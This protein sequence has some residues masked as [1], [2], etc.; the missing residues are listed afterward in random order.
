MAKT[1]VTNH[2]FYVVDLVRKKPKTQ[3]IEIP[4]YRVDVNIEVTT[5]ALLKTPKPAPSTAL[6]RLETAARDE[7]G[8]YETVIA[9]EAK[10]L[11]AKVVE[12]MKQ[13]SKAGEAEANKMIETTNSMI[14]KALAS[15][16]GA[17]QKAVEKR[18]KKE[19]QGDKLL[20]EA[21]VKTTVKVGKAIIKVS[22]SVAKLVAT[23]GAD[24]TS[25]KTIVTETVKMGL[26]LKQ[27]LKNEAKLRKDLDKAVLT[28]IK[29]RGS[30]IRQAIERQG[31][32]DTSGIDFTKPLVAIKGA[33]KKIQA[34][35]AEV[36]KGKDPKAILKNI[37]DF[38]IKSIKSYL[39]DCEKA[40]KAY[41]EHTTKTR[42][43]TDALGGSADKLM[44]AAKSAKSLK[45]GVR[46]G[47]ECMSI[48]R[49]ATAMGVKLDTREKYLDDMQ[50]LMKMNGL[51]IDDKTT[52]QKLKALDASTILTEGKGL[53]DTVKEVKGLVDNVVDAVT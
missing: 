37:A 21:R 43:K 25:Y 11:D 9:A 14:L 34:A 33:V 12:L 28:F 52:I 7:L 20:K 38:T 27:Q 4:A 29:L 41:R 24:V 10:R 15:A 45:E 6:K 53:I 32:K 31:L 26:E 51:E 40:R 18:L 47:A 42:H 3:Y 50:A 8:R 16:Q 13:P 30:S 23:A 5:K 22:A 39:A 36:T 17:A 48:K 35:G 2:K 49:Q 19:A 44:K 46:I 1:K